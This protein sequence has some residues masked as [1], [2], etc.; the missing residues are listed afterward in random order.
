MQERV[1]NDGEYSEPLP[2][3]N[4][5]VLCHQYCLAC[6]FSAMLTDAFHDCDAGINFPIRYE[7][8]TLMN[9]ENCIMSKVLFWTTNQ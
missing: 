8:Y 6:F 7:L 2:V 1:Q 9:L 3:T 5:A 4:K